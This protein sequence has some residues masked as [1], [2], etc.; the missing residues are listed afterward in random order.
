[1][2]L[3][4]DTHVALWWLADDDRVG[5]DAARQLDDASNRVLLSAAV[6]WEVAIKRSLGKLRAPAELT[7]T[8]LGAG[9]QPLP[10]TLEHASAVEALPWHHRDP[11]DR[12]LVAQAIVERATI[13]SHDD[14]LRSYDV[15]IIW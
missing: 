5:G 9:V 11:F 14:R 6:A 8:L 12:L 15:P 13:I 4:L 10:I 2:K 1:M 3:L 7:A